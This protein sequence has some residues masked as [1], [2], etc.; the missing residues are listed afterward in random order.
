MKYTCIK[1]NHQQTTIKICCEIFDV[2]QSG[3]YAWLSRKPSQR[4][5]DN[6][7]L[8]NKTKA[9]FAEHK[10]RAGSPRITLD[11][12]EDGECAAVLIASRGA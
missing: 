5:L 2:S 3:Y 6:G 1:A 12:Q 9:L 11:L 8:D 7:R 10:Q 4:S